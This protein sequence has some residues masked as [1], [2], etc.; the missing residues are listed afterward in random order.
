MSIKL[1]KIP[2]NVRGL[3][4]AFEGIDGSGKT[5]MVHYVRDKLSEKNISVVVCGGG[6][7]NVTK[8]VLN[9]VRSQPSA[10]PYTLGLAYAMDYFLQMETLILPA[11]QAGSV[12]LSDRYIFSSLAYNA[13][14]GL[15][16][17]WNSIVYRNSLEPHITFLLDISP[18]LALQRREDLDPIAT[19]F[20]KDFIQFQSKVRNNF[21]KLS[22]HFSFTVIEPGP[23]EQTALMILSH[24]LRALREKEL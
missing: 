2:D 8:E 12:V 24:I 5:S 23:I 9:Y 4:V 15:D 16:D 22:K 7:Y 1:Q 19:H 3:F 14:Y 17:E 21:L 13:A 20:G 18:S 6:Y 10:S 11:V